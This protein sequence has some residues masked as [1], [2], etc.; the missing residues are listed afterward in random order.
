MIFHPDVPNDNGFL[1]SLNQLKDLFTRHGCRQRLKGNTP[2]ELQAW[3]AESRVI[4]R[5][6]FGFDTFEP[7]DNK[8]I[9]L[10]RTEL[11]DHTRIKY[12]LQTEEKVY[13]PFFVL[14]PADLKAGEKRP[15][16]I[17]PNGHFARAKESVAAVREEENVL[18][19]IDEF[20]LAYGEDF[21]KMGCIAFCPDARGFG[22]RAERARQP[23]GEWKC[24]CTHLN[25]MGI[26]L[27][28]S[29]LGMCIWDLVKLTDYITTRDD[30]DA[31]NIGCGGLSGGGMQSMYLAAVDERIKCVCTSG[32]FYGALES[33]LTMNENCD[34]NYVPN[35][36]KYFDMGDIAAMIAPR[37][38]IIETGEKDPLNG[39]SGINNITPQ[40]EIAQKAYSVTGCDDKIIHVVFDAGHAWGGHETYPFFERYLPIN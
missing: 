36:W 38:L 2:E 4:L 28:R 18:K 21:V 1:T 26:P 31:S 37:P 8:V 11:P 33:L 29:A 5:N 19:D 23:E 32:Y 39:E 3:Q 22:E 34:C 20:N 30:C 14:I 15:A 13:V 12:V 27:G 25:R 24:T 35:M 17:C 9:E 16:V 6:V 40:L 7:C 10:D